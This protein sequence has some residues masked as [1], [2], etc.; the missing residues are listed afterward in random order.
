LSENAFNILFLFVFS[1]SAH[2]KK[3]RMMAFGSVSMA[4]AK[5]SEVGISCLPNSQYLTML[6]AIT[7]IILCFYIVIMF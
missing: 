3:K 1:G 2:I 4:A 7:L 6:F 5:N